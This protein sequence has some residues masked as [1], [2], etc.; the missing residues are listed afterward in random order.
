VLLLL[1]TLWAAGCG[2]DPA[3]PSEDP[4]EV[5][6]PASPALAT[7]DLPGIRKT[8]VLR[9]LA[10]R[11][12]GAEHLPRAGWP[13]DRE[14][15]HAETLA[16]R[17][18]LEAEWVSV[19]SFDDLLPALIEGRGD[20]I[21]GNLT[22][23]RER[24]RSVAFS[25]PVTFVREQVVA[26]ATD[27]DLRRI[28]DL[29]G[30]RVAVRR[31]SSF[32]E[33]IEALRREHPGIVL[34]AVPESLAIDEILE[35]VA[36]GTYDVSLADSNLVASVLG[37]RDDLR[38]AFEL[39]R[40]T[41]IAW[42][43]RRD[44]VRLRRAVDEFLTT[45]SLAIEAPKL[46]TGDLAEIRER[47]VLRVI[48][49]NNAANYYIWNGQLM[50]FEYDLAREFAKR[51]KLELEIVVPPSHDDLLPWLRQGRGDVVAASLTASPERAAREEV[52]FSRRANRVHETVVTRADDESLLAVEDL[53]GRRFHVRRGSH[54]W[55]TLEALRDSGIALE[56]VPVPDTLET[57]EIIERVATGRYD[58]TLADSHIVDIERTWRSDIRAALTIGEPVDLGWAVRPD[59]PELLAAVNAFFRKEYRGT[60]YNVL[61]RRYF[62]E[63][64][65][66]RSHAEDRPLRAGRISPFDGSVQKYAESYG[67]DWRLIAAQMHQESRFDPKARS[68]AG[69]RGLMQVMP[70]TAS[71]L[72]VED[73]E[74]P[75]TGIYA[76]VLYM[77]RMRDRFEDQLPASERLWFALASYNVGYGH[78]RDARQLAAANGYDPNRWFGNVERAILLK[79]RRDVAS[80]TRFGYCRC[81]EPVRYVREIR[82][83][84]RAYVQ[85]AAGASTTKAEVALDFVD[86]A[87]YRDPPP[88]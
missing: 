68:Y 25:A 79:R 62:A 83:R 42:A 72:G 70:R 34:E 50:G 46:H 33:S 59:N 17:L 44:A 32:W 54:Y 41:V 4:A 21:A 60:I 18:G 14:R 6:P 2:V 39:D 28:S 61:A 66:I 77:S 65:R 12:D 23:T 75:D 55:E 85:V 8:G 31:S 10:T 84:Y 81:S 78:V 27:V 30:R 48:T 73:L 35:R 36:N 13:I 40:M 29:V 43:M 87:T 88:L 74:D 37:Y 38:V 20:L 86:P 56:L 51:Q 3:D 9:L 22:A 71:E 19:E 45:T 47:G 69:A 80:R 15:A 5:G 52:A 82:D 1:G 76:G 53:A 57:E 11:R 63:P 67:F 16:R 24:S 64:K 49:R 58:L 26:R 7:Q